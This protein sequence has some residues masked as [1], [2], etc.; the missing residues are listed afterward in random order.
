MPSITIIISSAWGSITAVSEI[1]VQVRITVLLFWL[2]AL[3]I[4]SGWAQI[5]HSENQHLPEVM[6]PL[7]VEDHNSIKSS[8]WI[9]YSLKFEGQRH[10]IR[11]K[12]TKHLLAQNMPVFTYTSQ[13]SLHQDHPFTQNNCYYYGYVEGELKSQVSLDSCLGGLKGIIY[14]DNIVY[15]IV[16]KMHS[17]KFEHMVY[18]LKSEAEF[19][20]RRCG[21]IDEE[22]QQLKFF[23]NDDLSTSMQS[24]YTGWWTQKKY[25]ELGV[26]VDNNRYLHHESNITEVQWEVSLVV[27]LVNVFL[28][29][30]N[31]DVSLKGIEIWTQK[32]LVA[33]DSLEVLLENFCIWKRVHLN[34]RLD[35]DVAHL[36]VKISYSD[37]VGLAYVGTVCNDLYNCAVSS[38]MNDDII[39]FGYIMSHELGHNLG[40]RHDDENCVCGEP[41]CI[42]HP[43]IFVASQ[44]SNCSYSQYLRT[45]TGKDC[46]DFPIN[47]ENTLQE[48]RCG[49]G[50]VE[51]KEECDCGPIY[52][53]AKDPCCEANCTLTPG[54]LCASGLCC[55]DCKILPAGTLCRKK[56]NECDLPEWCNGTSH[57]C[58][59]D[60]YVQAGISCK[61]G[62][63]C[64]EKRCNDR[65]EQC[66][67]IFGRESKSA[68]GLCYKEANSRGD[69]F[70]HC[71]LNNMLRYTQCHI[72]DSL[73]GRIQCENVR[74][75]PLLE[76]H[77]TLISTNISGHNCWSTD[78]HVG[79]TIPDIGEVKD[80]TACG[81]NQICMRQKCIPLADFKSYCSPLTCNM[82]GICNNRHHCHCDAKLRPP[83]CIVKGYGG[84]IDSGPPPREFSTITEI[85]AAGLG[86]YWFIISLLRFLIFILIFIAVVMKAD[87]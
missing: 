21:L 69:R 60:V 45:C 48:E 33:V 83:H 57:E 73:C 15:K 43:S 38:F 5:V 82:N 28:Q 35:H 30:L 76:N 20:V 62:G 74:K 34:D 10:I 49:N 36:F 87:S 17:T 7:K 64:Y 42:M 25:L 41:Y 79:M 63:H 50:V 4:Y 44:F 29:S 80:G 54:A 13:G 85:L 12:I 1:L 61:G 75:I 84:S 58:P 27:N 56:E 81:E 3:F 37:R 66:R 11:M 55:K 70:G 18:K 24:G 8:D 67:K 46:L 6:I 9:S 19:P 65:D 32:N 59:E 68:N 72:K 16:P 53:C 2:K 52:L 51:N 31:I 14:K 78:Y 86:R 77:R 23:K 40:M 39:N 26:V 47:S 71:S 22:I